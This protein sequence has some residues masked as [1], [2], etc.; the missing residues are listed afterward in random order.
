[1]EDSITPTKGELVAQCDRRQLRYMSAE[2]NAPC[3]YCGE[4]NH[5]GDL[6]AGHFGI[7]WGH[8]TCVIMAYDDKQLILSPNNK[9]KIPPRMREAANREWSRAHGTV[10]LNSV[11]KPSPWRESKRYTDQVK[12]EFKESSDTLI[13]AEHIEKAQGKSL[14]ALAGMNVPGPFPVDTKIGKDWDEVSDNIDALHKEAVDENK[15]IVSA[16]QQAKR[17]E[18]G[19][20]TGRWSCKTKNVMNQPRPENMKSSVLN[21]MDY[22]KHEA[23]VLAIYAALNMEKLYDDP[24][25]RAAV[26][27]LM[28][29]H[30]YQQ[31]LGCGAFNPVIIG[32][33]FM[34]PSRRPSET[35]MEAESC[36]KP[37]QD[38]WGYL[39]REKL[40][41]FKLRSHKL[42]RCEEHDGRWSLSDDY[43]VRNDL[44][45]NTSV[46][47]G[48]EVIMADSGHEWM[49]YMWYVCN[50]HPHGWD[51]KAGRVY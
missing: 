50:G 35:M 17:P 36:M 9:S 13:A 46:Q 21:T 43:C 51:G 25:E 41:L 29:A 18:F 5:P 26:F 19:V 27:D 20:V 37:L 34:P 10:H 12:E 28:L 22:A 23:R 39:L 3:V 7:R 11:G 1:M 38:E 33:L 45:L 32:P 30:P 4:P 8:A 47:V 16:R 48:L 6:I 14:K 40:N 31:P 15:V 24:A 42:P 49:R 44:A 2:R